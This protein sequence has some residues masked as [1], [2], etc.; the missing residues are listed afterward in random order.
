M[1]YIYTDSAAI[2]IEKLHQEF[3]ANL[4][5][6]VHKEK[7]IFGDD[8]VEITGYDV[9]SF[10]DFQRKGSRKAAKYRI[11]RMVAALYVFI[12]FCVLI[13]GVFYNQLIEI[14]LMRPQQAAFIFGGFGLVVLG[15]VLYLLLRNKERGIEEYY[16]KEDVDLADIIR[17]NNLSGFDSPKNSREVNIESQKLKDI[18]K[19]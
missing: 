1:K 13:G 10:Y 16:A 11:A 18:S 6:K 15:C 17:K 2:E 4:E 9:R 3:K 14:Y 8:S 12:G 19:K 5:K 7:Y